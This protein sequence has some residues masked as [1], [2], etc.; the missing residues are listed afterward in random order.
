MAIKDDHCQ[1]SQSGKIKIISNRLFRQSLQVDAFGANKAME[2]KEEK[3]IK[4]IIFLGNH[5]SI[6]NRIMLRR[7]IKTMNQ[8]KRIWNL[9][10]GYTAAG[11]ILWLLS[12][13]F[14]IAQFIAESAWKTPP[15]NWQLNAISDLG[16]I[17]C[18]EFD[19]RFVCSPLHDLMNTSL[20]ILGLCMVIG[21]V[22][23]YQ[24]LRRSRVGF[25]MMTL[26]GF[27]AILVGIFPEDTIYWAHIVGQ[28]LA[29][30][31][32]NI[33]LIIFGF[34]WRLKPWHK[35]YSI[36]SGSVALVALFLFLSH[37]RFFLGL[38]GMER[39]VCYPLILWLIVT[40]MYL[41]FFKSKISDN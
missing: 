15:Y 38:G 6:T 35:W 5:K 8:L 14:F 11:P 20:I 22:L 19:G 29:F 41:S 13:H 21:S 12:I 28:D 4:Q 16:A 24:Q 2:A 7:I 34:T 30:V 33:A 40:G 23:I 18:G 17:S 39:I 27:G 3:R 1:I 9:A 10:I 31:F 32:G 36:I 25:I 37:N 26:A